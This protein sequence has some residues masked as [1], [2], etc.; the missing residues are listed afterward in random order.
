MAKF[1]T[2]KKLSGSNFLKLEVGETR[3]LQIVSAIVLGTMKK[4]PAFFVDVVDMETNDGTVH[5]LLLSTVLHSLISENYKTGEYLNRGFSITK[6]EKIVGV[7]NAY[8]G[9]TV[10]EVE[11]PETFGRK[12]KS[13]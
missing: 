1:K 5:K 7:D 6:T 4:K 11:V 13:A 3:F 8:N 10:E 9:F 12:L 2:I